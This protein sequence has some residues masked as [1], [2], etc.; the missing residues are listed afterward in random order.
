MSFGSDTKTM[1]ER[2]NENDTSF[3]RLLDYLI[4][5]I[6][7]VFESPLM[8]FSINSYILFYFYSLYWP[9]QTL[10]GGRNALITS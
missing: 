1:V 8:L 2:S 6:F 4:T 3:E 10:D 9:R 7:Q 5:Y